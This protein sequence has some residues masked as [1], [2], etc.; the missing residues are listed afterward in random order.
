MALGRLEN[1]E[2]PIFDRVIAIFEIAWKT[3]A[4]TE[5]LPNGSPTPMIEH[6]S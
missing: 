2:K 4:R 6:E 3:Q 1:Y 5:E